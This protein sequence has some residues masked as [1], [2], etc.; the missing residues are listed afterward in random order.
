MKLFFVAIYMAVVAHPA[1]VLCIYLAWA[2]TPPNLRLFQ[3]DQILSSGGTVYI[4]LILGSLILFLVWAMI[5][6]Q[7]QRR[8]VVRDYDKF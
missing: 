1:A 5:P 6:N 8:Q 7:V 2:R 4:G 3:L